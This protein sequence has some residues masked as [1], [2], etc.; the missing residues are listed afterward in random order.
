MIVN[1]SGRF[2]LIVLAG[3][4]LLAGL[5]AGLVRFGWILPVL[6]DQFPFVHG[7]VMV[8]GFLGTLIGL[9]RAVALG[10]VWPYG[11][12]ILT[13]LS[14]LSVLTGVSWN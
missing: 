7:P 5:W 4:F 9:E 2:V 3:L 11:I 1:H 6:N 14:M 10:R 8:V 13:A 12:P